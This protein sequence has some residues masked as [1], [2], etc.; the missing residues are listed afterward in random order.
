MGVIFTV[1]DGKATR[2]AGLFGG[3]IL[4]PGRISDDGLR[5]YIASVDHWGDVTR[6]MKV[7]VE[8]QNHPM[9]DGF[10]GKLERLASRK[11]G[12][13]NPFVVGSDSYQK[14]VSV[15]ST[16]TKAQLARRKGA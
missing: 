11:P 14:F 12:D 10:L 2:I 3:S 4:T 9:Y 15:M 16:C 5:Q 13:P 6:K 7:D 8:I 1:K